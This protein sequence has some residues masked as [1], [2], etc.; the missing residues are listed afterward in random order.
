MLASLNSRW[1][2]AR[3]YLARN[4]LDGLEPE[5]R[6]F[7]VETCVL[8]SLSGR[9]CDELLARRGSGPAVAGARDEADLHVRARRRLVSLPRD[10]PL[11]AR[12]D[13]RREARGAR[14]AAALSP[15][16]HAARGGGCPIRRTP[17][18]LPCGSVGGRPATARSRRAPDRRRPTALAR[19]ASARDRR[20]RPVAPTCGGTPATGGR[21]VR[22]PRSRRIGAPSSS[23]AD[24]YRRTCVVA[25]ASRS[26]SGSSPARRRRKARSGCCAQRRSATH[27]SRASRPLGSGHLRV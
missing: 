27:A 3:E 12:G 16:G 1:S 25:S 18:V 10:A 11:A 26:R 21:A 24:R 8:T 15:G 23:L 6:D 19:R 14:W 7:L 20:E 5:L 4:V 2:V 17:R 13:A 22:R 9:V